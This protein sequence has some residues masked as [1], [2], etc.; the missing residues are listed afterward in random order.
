MTEP[1]KPDF[2]EL[3]GGDLSSA[4]YLNTTGSSASTTCS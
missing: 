1:R 3:V 2:R 4:S